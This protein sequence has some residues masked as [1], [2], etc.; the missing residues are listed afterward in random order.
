MRKYRNEPCEVGGEKYRSKREMRRHQDLVL[1][2]RAGLISD[3]RREMP[4]VLAPATRINGRLKPA[5]RYVADF[6]YVEHG[7]Q[8]VEDA[9][10]V[11]TQVFRIKQH[12]MAT[13]H[14]IVVR[15]V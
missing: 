8:R 15:E 2:E 9:K 3:L 1:L 7:H 12:L 6:V 10:G 13:I 4:F 14:G 11:R 5:L